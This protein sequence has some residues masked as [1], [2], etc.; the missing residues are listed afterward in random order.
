MVNDLI[1][2]ISILITWFHDNAALLAVVLGALTAL[3]RTIWDK[4]DDDVKIKCPKA[5]KTIEFIA[6]I[7]PDI[8]TASGIIF[9]VIKSMLEKRRGK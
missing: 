1:N 2:F 6:S 3:L 9:T 5:Y 4:I 8:K 7:S